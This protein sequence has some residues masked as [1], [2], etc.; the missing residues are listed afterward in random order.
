MDGSQ[1]HPI[2]PGVL[3]N[4]FNAHE[5]TLIAISKSN[6]ALIIASPPSPRTITKLVEFN[7]FLINDS[8]TISN[9]CQ[10]SE[11]L[12]AS[13]NSTTFTDYRSTLI[14]W[15]LILKRMNRN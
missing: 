11:S 10:E 7:P 9:M 14:S 2:L 5:P 4:Q 13:L 12:D 8:T 6:S 3:A 1:P 15:G